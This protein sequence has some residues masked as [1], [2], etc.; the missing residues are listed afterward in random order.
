MDQLLISILIATT[1]G[2]FLAVD[3]ILTENPDRER[4]EIALV[5]AFLVFWMALLTVQIQHFL[6]SFP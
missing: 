3:Y 6:R 5:Y 2:A 1:P 4:L